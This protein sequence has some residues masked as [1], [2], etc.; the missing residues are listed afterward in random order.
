[1]S[2][3]L[4]V[5]LAIV[6]IVL[7]FVFR[8]REPNTQRLATLSEIESAI[9]RLGGIPGPTGVIDI[10]NPNPAPHP[11]IVTNQYQ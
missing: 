10:N 9:A 4:I 3:N 11:G 5:L 1:M 2:K 7:Y 6:A 8:K